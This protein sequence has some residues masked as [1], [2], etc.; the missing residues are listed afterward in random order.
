MGEARRKGATTDHGGGR[1]TIEGDAD[2]LL[3]RGTPAEALGALLGMAADV[4]A[5]MAARVVAK[6]MRPEGLALAAID[7]ADPAGARVAG[8]LGSPEALAAARRAAPGGERPILTGTIQRARMVT[9]VEALDAAMGRHVARPPAGHL[10]VLVVAGGHLSVSF[11]PMP[12]V[13][14]AEAFCRMRYR[15]EESGDVVT[16]WNSRDGVTPFTFRH[17]DTGEAFTHFDF[18]G[19]VRAPDHVPSRG[20]LVFVDLTREVALQRRRAYVTRRW[21][22]AP[23]SG[24]PLRDAYPGMT[25]EQ[26]AAQLADADLTPGAPDLVRWGDA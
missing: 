10:P 12:G 14:P 5:A 17:P 13:A 11:E 22:R 26:V 8:Y 9:V 25:W 6:G 3:D 21:G 20:D 16:V 18:G 4:L 23:E 15:G 2:D 19:D 1:V 24:T 7:L